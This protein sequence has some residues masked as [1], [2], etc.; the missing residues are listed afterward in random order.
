MCALCLCCRFAVSALYVCRVLADETG[1]GR[2]SNGEAE[3]C[4]P[5]LAAT[6]CGSRSACFDCLA[7]TLR[8]ESLSLRRCVAPSGALARH[9]ERLK[10]KRAGRIHSIHWHLRSCYCYQI[11]QYALYM[12]WCLA[13]QYLHVSCLLAPLAYLMPAPLAGLSG[14]SILLPELGDVRLL[15][16]SFW[17]GR[18]VSVLCKRL[19]KHQNQ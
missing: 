2:A 16:V 15:C 11:H 12:V 3:R 9:Q 4:M 14:W 13:V 7:S 1:H 18:Q 19:D 17:I 10:R 5:R 8:L 6:G